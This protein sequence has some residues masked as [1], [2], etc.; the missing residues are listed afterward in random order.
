MSKGDLVK[1]INTLK[2]SYIP[3]ENKYKRL[4]YIFKLIDTDGSGDI[5]QCEMQTFYNTI[6]LTVSPEQISKSIT[7]STKDGK[8]DLVSFITGFDFQRISD[9]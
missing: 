2:D 3:S 1:L 5:D 6:G 7:E 9:D 8:F 4:K